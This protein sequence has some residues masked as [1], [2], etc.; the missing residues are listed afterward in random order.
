MKEKRGR[1]KNSESSKSYTVSLLPSKR[2]FL[3]KKYGSL[4]KAIKTLLP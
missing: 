3:V 4:T 1:P 2:N